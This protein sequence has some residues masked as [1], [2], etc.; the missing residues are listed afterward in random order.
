MDFYFNTSMDST[1]VRK[2][3]TLVCFHPKQAIMQNT[4]CFSTIYH[5]WYKKR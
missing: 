2:Y 5:E 1:Y 3:S 4:S